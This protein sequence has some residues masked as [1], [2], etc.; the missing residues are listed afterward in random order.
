[1]F[2]GK[3]YDAN[4][5]FNLTIENDTISAYVIESSDLWHERLARVNFRS[6]QLMMK[7]D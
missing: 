2:V 5:T 6:I 4:G 1:M 7:M 3:D